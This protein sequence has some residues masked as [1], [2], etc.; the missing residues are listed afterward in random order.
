[1]DAYC[2][3]YI[4]YR[5]AIMVYKS[6]NDLGPEYM[7]NLF[8]FVRQVHSRTTRPSCANDLYLPPGKHKQ[9]YKRLHIAVLRYGTH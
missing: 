3:S 1:M 7:T 8:R 6:L 5:K 9:I 2:R 4:D